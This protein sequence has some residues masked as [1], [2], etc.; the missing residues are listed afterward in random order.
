MTAAVMKMDST[1]YLKLRH[2]NPG[3]ISPM[4]AKRKTIVG[5]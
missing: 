1:A 4:R 3:V 5:I 2:K